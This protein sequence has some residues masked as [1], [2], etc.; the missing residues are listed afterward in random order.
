MSKWHLVWAVVSV[1]VAYGLNAR[2][3]P[4]IDRSRPEAELTAPT[5]QLAL[6]H[7]RGRR[8]LPL[9]D[10][11]V[12]AADID[13]P[14]NKRIAVREISLRSPSEGEPDMELFI[15][16]DE[17]GMA[18]DARKLKPVVGKALP[19]VP[20]VIGGLRSR[21]TIKGTVHEVIGGTCTFTQALP[22]AQGEEM[23]SWRVKGKLD[24]SLQTDGA[25]EP[26]TATFKA[27][28]VW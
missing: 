24:L 27:R 5:G 8:E 21:V 3:R 6:S 1:G 22:M 11:R 17:G 19:I 15:A 10:A 25:P 23:A 14:F 12:L 13:Y 9:I 18:V 26:A 16:F 4:E 2:A 20:E 28:V 7:A